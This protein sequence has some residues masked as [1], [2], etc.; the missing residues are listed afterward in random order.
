VLVTGGLGAIGSFVTAAMLA[1]GARVTTF[2][3]TAD[4]STLR[5]LAPEAGLDR[6]TVVRG[7]LA[8]RGG[9]MRA[10]AQARPELIVALSSLLI[11]ASDQDPA[12]AYDVNLGGVL[13]CLQ[14]AASHGAARVVV[15]SAKAA[16]GALP[17]RYGPPGFEPVT[18]DVR[19]GPANVYGLTKRAV[20]DLCGY[21]RERR[22]VDVS[23]LRLGSTYG[24]GKEGHAGYSSL[25][26]RIVEAAARGGHVLVSGENVLDDVVYNRDVASAV[27]RAALAAPAGR[28]HHVY[29]ISGGEL[30]S[31][32]DFV[33]EVGRCC[34]EASV[35]F[36]ETG[37]PAAGGLRMRMDISRAAREIGFVPAFPGTAG[38]ADYVR[39]ARQRVGRPDRPDRPDSPGRPAGTPGRVELTV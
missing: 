34:P 38:I 37:H 12:A 4:L 2:G 24:P 29:N 39:I 35:E 6:L 31:I 20:E 28:R 22:G 21:Y 7:D 17:G 15:A 33:A 10:A 1:A 25:K 13:Q 26:T 14:A 9:L 16:Y 23:C 3:R 11:R 27:L 32:R 8:A 30:V 5:L 18:E 36:T 19:S